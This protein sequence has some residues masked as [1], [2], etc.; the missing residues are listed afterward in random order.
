MV[1]RSV[2]F[3]GHTVA[4]ETDSIE[5]VAKWGADMKVAAVLADLMM[6]R[7]DGIEILAVWQERRPEV[8]RV[9][10]TAAPTEQMVRDAQR[11]GIVQ[12]LI[13]K[14]WGLSD[15]ESALDWL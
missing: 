14:P 8:R 1:A 5:A 3:C 2:E 9:L 6:P 4:V 13:A 7:L 12:K 11:D 15:I 10:I